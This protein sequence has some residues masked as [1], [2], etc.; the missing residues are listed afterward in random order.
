MGLDSGVN[1][2]AVVTK[3]RV[4]AVTIGDQCR[5][6]LWRQDRKLEYWIELSSSS[7]NQRRE[8]GVL[9]VQPSWALSLFHLLQVSVFLWLT[10]H[11]TALRRAE[12]TDNRQT[13]LKREYDAELRE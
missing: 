3:V 2:K 4:E 12:D 6:V 7:D 11:S 13:K 10:P 9:G 5:A 1:G 8:G